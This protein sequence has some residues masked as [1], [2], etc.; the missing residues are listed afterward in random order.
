[1]ASVGLPMSTE[2]QRLAAVPVSAAA[3]GIMAKYHRGISQNGIFLR[4]EINPI[5]DIK[6]KPITRA[7][8][9]WRAEPI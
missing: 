7:L 3:A 6:H 8:S 5:L 2:E 1:M 9:R 4:R